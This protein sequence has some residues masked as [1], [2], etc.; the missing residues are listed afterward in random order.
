MSG[1]KRYIDDPE[2]TFEETYTNNHIPK[3]RQVRGQ[4]V[5]PAYNKGPLHERLQAEDPPEEGPAGGEVFTGYAKRALIE[6]HNGP[7]AL[8][9]DEFETRNNIIDAGVAESATPLVFDPD[10]LSLLRDE[11]PLAFE[12]LTRR[13]QEGYQVVFNNVSSREGP[14]GYGPE[15]DTANLQDDARDFTFQNVRVDLAKYM[16]S[17]TITDF[18]AE[19]SAHYMDLEELTVGARMAEYAQLHEQTVL[20]GDPTIAT[21]AAG[22]GQTGGPGDPNAFKGLATV[23]P[24]TDKS[25]NGANV[26]SDFAKNI[27][28]EIRAL[29]QSDFAV[30]AT[31]LE[32][33]CSWSMYDTLENEFTS[34]ARHDENADS[35]N[36]GDYGIQIGGVPVIP[37]HNVDSHTYN[38]PG[39]TDYSVGDDGDVFLCNVATAEYRELL[40]LTTIPLAQRGAAEEV[41]MVE[42]GTLIERSGDS[43]SGAI[44]DGS[45]DFGKYLS[46]YEI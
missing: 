45:A 4:W 16:D 23:Y 3:T 28:S 22:D 13:G 9:A 20:Y 8:D 35:L 17:A 44:S 11:A 1:A 24:E 29:L 31:D 41:G 36:F 26:T 39:G 33:W 25:S 40:P 32:V 30:S 34:R 7:K 21:N 38:D 12:R 5:T 6:A 14:R 46:G 10:V 15:A 18:S 37:S 42:F 27:K 2:R 43:G 19:A